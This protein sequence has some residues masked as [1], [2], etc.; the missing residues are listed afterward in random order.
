MHVVLNGISFDLFS[1]NTGNLRSASGFVIG[2]A[3]RLSPEKGQVLLLD[4]FFNVHERMPTSTLRFCGSGSQQSLLRQMA[5]T[6]GIADAVHFDG[7]VSDID[8]WYRRLDA[9]VVPSLGAEG[10]PRVIMEAMYCGIPIIAADTAG[11]R[12]SV[13]D[14]VTGFVIPV[15]NSQAIFRKL[16]ELAG[17]MDLRRQMGAEASRVAADRFSLERVTR[18]VSALYESLLGS[19]EGDGDCAGWNS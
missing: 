15:G 19:R 17:N 8:R 11:S 3:G 7:Q 16:E 5:E 1:T 10:L 14:G 12:E 2:C 9:L 6:R 4:A 13:I 18:E